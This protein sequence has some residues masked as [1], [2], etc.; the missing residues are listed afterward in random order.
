MKRKIPNPRF[1]VADLVQFKMLKKA[2]LAGGEFW[3]DIDDNLIPP[4]AIGLIVS[5]KWATFEDGECW[6]YDVS[7]PDL[8][9]VST[10]WGDYAFVALPKTRRK[11]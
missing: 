5:R 2:K 7:I 8:G 3:I 9:V 6:E 4:G 11:K 1:D 10:G